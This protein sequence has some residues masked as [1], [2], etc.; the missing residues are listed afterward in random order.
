MRER[1]NKMLAQMS[2][3][4]A[5]EK[6]ERQIIDG[7]GYAASCMMT[8]DEPKTKAFWAGEYVAYERM[9]QICFGTSDADY[10][11]AVSW[12]KREAGLE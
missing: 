5:I 2:P 3:T 4:Q 6:V 10:I 7:K 12:A 9:A 8:A 11:D 1:S